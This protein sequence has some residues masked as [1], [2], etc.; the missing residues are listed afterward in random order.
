MKMPYNRNY[1][2]T[3]TFPEPSLSNLEAYVL[4]IRW[5]QLRMTRAQSCASDDT[6]PCYCRSKISSLPPGSRKPLHMRQHV[7]CPL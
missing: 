7:A 1:I 3:R 6:Y 4:A 5:W 2:I